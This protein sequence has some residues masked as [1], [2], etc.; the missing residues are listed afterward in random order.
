MTEEIAG[1][2]GR[3]GGL[4]DPQGQPIAPP[5]EDD[6]KAQVAEAM[7]DPWVRQLIIAIITSYQ[8]YAASR[9]MLATSGYD[10]LV[11]QAVV[12]GAMADLVDPDTGEHKGF[13]IAKTRKRLKDQVLPT[14]VQVQV[15]T[16]E[17]QRALREQAMEEDRKLRETAIGLS[18]VDP[19][20]QMGRGEVHALVVPEGTAGEVCDD[21]SR[22]LYVED[23]RFLWMSALTGEP[24]TEMYETRREMSIAPR[25]ACKDALGTHRKKAM[26]VPFMDLFLVEDWAHCMGDRGPAALQRLFDDLEARGMSILATFED[27][28]SIPP[29]CRIWKVEL[30]RDN[31]EAEP[32]ERIRITSI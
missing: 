1:P 23:V 4:V 6:I 7:Q 16:Q 17:R 32:K 14:L 22:V 19:G 25:E 27:E 21:L 8:A 2:P 26:G 15:R 24:F 12:Q 31:P 30:R 3:D 9:E 29:G 10:P 28:A 20:R 18:V 5:V 11:V 13:D